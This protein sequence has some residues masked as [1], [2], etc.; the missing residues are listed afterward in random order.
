MN[1][2]STLPHIGRMADVID[3]VPAHSIGTDGWAREREREI[4]IR[5]KA[6]ANSSMEEEGSRASEVYLSGLESSHVC[7]LPRR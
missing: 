7:L 4:E 6:I 1:V 3:R 5:E 2:A